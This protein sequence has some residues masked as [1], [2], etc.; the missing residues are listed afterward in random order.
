MLKEVD[1]F[2]SIPSSV[3]LSIGAII[4]F[5]LLFYTKLEKMEIHRF[6]FIFFSIIS[7]LIGE[8]IYVYHQSFLG[9]A[10]PYPSIADIFYL[11]VT[12][13]L[14]FHLYNVLLLKRNI[15]KPKSFIYL[16]FLASVFPIY[17]F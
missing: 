2:N 10:L 12:V 17:R 11:S 4:S 1:F 14:S 5:K 13:F 9:I 6:R 3:I 8:L 16:G 7:W 15:I